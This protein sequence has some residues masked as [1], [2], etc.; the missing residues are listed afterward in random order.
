MKHIRLLL[1]SLLMTGVASAQSSR[2]GSEP[3]DYSAY[4][5][6]AWENILEWQSQSKNQVRMIPADTTRAAFTLFRGNYELTSTL[7]AFVYHSGGMMVDNGWLRVLGSGSKDFNRGIFE[8]NKDKYVWGPDSIAYL[9]IAD[10]VVGGFFALFMTPH[11]E[12][13]DAFVYYQGPNDRHWVST[14]LDYD[15]FLQFC[16]FG[17]IKMFYN[18]YRWDGWKEEIHLI[19]SNQTISCYPQ[20]WREGARDTKLKRRV[21]PVQ[22]LWELYNPAIKEL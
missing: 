5:E 12:L 11:T 6:S 8:W 1:L 18:N 3:V 21:I 7:A 19:N 4:T 17:E 2:K 20:Y 9:M 13:D 16:F 14:G 15:G 10:D 22:R